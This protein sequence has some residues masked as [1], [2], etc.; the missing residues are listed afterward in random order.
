[1]QLQS[2]WRSAPASICG[3]ARSLVMTPQLQQAIKLLQ[4]SNIE[5][6]A[7]VEEE[8]ERNPL[9]ERDERADAGAAER[10]APDQAAA[11][12]QRR[13]GRRRRRRA[14]AT[15]CRPR[16]R[17]AGHADHAET[18]RPRRRR[19]TAVAAPGRGGSRRFRGRRPRHRRLS[20][21]APHP[22]RA[23]RRAA[24]PD[25]RRPG[26]PADR[27]APDRA[28]RARRAACRST[29]AAIA[30]GAGRRRW[31]GSRRCAAA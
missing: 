12:R 29:P 27:R 21:N 31:S 16:R 8:L 1:M 24:A 11:R 5:V 6:A 4:F 18:V 26:R 17:A 7:F 25:L 28:A 10:P 9:L 3:R 23:S 20:P 14:L 15:C 30:D 22:A 13:T 19:R 2:R